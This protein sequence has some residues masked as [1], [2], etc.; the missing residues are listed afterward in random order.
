MTIIRLPRLQRLQGLQLEG[1]ERLARVRA[2][3]MTGVM[4]EGIKSL[5][6]LAPFPDEVSKDNEVHNR[7]G[8][9]ALYHIIDRN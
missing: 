4:A 7:K 8:A 6:E 2:S 1:L 3:L 9:S 5:S